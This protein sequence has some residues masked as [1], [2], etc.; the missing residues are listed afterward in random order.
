MNHYE[1]SESKQL[2]LLEGGV[3]IMKKQPAKR[4]NIVSLKISEG[5]KPIVQGSL[6][7]KSRRWLP[8]VEAI[9]R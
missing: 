3:E 7:S 2:E 8:I 9:L 5:I 4:V 1:V 6:C